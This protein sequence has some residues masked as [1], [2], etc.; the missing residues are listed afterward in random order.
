[1]TGLV[2]DH[3]PFDL[4]A[5]IVAVAVANVERERR[6]QDAMREAA[7]LASLTVYRRGQRDKALARGVRFFSLAFVLMMGVAWIAEQRLAV[8]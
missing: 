2:I 1:M 6:E 8:M 7:R 3:I 5:E 4:E